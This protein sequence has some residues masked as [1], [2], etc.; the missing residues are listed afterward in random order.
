MNIRLIIGMFIAIWFT[1]AVVLGF[2]G[3]L[4]A[5]PY[6]P[7]VAAP[8]GLSVP[9][10]LFP[11]MYFASVKFRN[12]I[13]DLDLAL[14]TNLQ[15]WR[16][17]GCIF[18]VL[19]YYELLPG[20]FAWPATIGDLLVGLSAPYVV[21][22]ISQQRTHWRRHL[23]ILTIIG[24]LDFVGAYATAVLTGS[25][26]IGILA[27]DTTSDIL[28]QFPLSLFPTFLVPFWITLH[29]ITIIQLRKMNKSITG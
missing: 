27:G 28:A 4:E 29:I 11:V 5:R 1:L 21:S 16:V 10:L 14:L 13:L 9:L 8:F 15:T 7:P 22:A 25:S 18:I 17:S 2:L 26:A 12:F 24:I 6:R 3:I 19:Y 20:F 23:V